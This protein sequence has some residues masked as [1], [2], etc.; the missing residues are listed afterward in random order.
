MLAE[1]SPAL[2]P[3]RGRATR[4]PGSGGDEV[5]FELLTGDAV[6]VGEA[7]AQ[8]FSLALPVFP[9]SPDAAIEV[10][11]PVPETGPFA[12]LELLIRGP[13]K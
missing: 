8:E 12:A 9:R 2:R 6:D 1:S 5:A 13:S 7:V 4:S 3:A 11:P 10:D